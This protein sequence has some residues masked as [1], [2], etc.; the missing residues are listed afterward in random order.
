MSA[1]PESVLLSRPLSDVLGAL[2]SPHELSSGGAPAAALAAAAAAALCAKAA[3][4]SRG[5]WIEAGGAIAQAEALRMQTQALI[6]RDADVIREASP[7]LVP[8]ERSARRGVAAPA[9][10]ARVDTERDR[11]VGEAVAQAADLALA[12]AEAASLI[13]QIAAEVARECPAAMRPDAWTAVT[14]AEAAA[15]ASARLVEANPKVEHDDPRRRSAF[16]CAHAARE[17]RERTS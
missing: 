15:C 13:A 12:T 17:A 1:A 9:V 16:E 4:A 11:L 7:V 2:A 6:E 8:D 14:L 10:G 3:R 5:S